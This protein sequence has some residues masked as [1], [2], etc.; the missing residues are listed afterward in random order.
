MAG[1]AI[2][3][4]AGAPGALQ[5]ELPVP[6]SGV[7]GGFLIIITGQPRGSLAVPP[8]GESHVIYMDSL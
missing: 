1:S 5:L 3:G 7:V 6:Q 2:P 8:G 4:V